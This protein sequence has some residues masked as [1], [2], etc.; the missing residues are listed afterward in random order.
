[1]TEDPPIGQWRGTTVYHGTHSGAV[2][3]IADGLRVPET[4][5]YFGNAFYTAAS[6]ASAHMT[7]APDAVAEH[8]GEP[9]VLAVKIS[10]TANILD[11]RVE[12]D[13]A[14]WFAISKKKHMGATDW[15]DF[16]TS[17]GI[18]GVFDRSTMGVAI[19]NP[20][21][22]EILGA[23][24]RTG[25][26]A[27]LQ[28]D[29]HPAL[30]HATKIAKERF[31]LESELHGFDHWERVERNGA[32]LASKSKADPLVVAIFARLHDCCRDD[33]HYDEEHGPK[34]ARLFLADAS[35]KKW[36]TPP[37][38]RKTA[39]ALSTHTEAAGGNADATVGVCLDSDRLDL[40]R[41][42]CDI[43]TSYLSTQAAID[44][45]ENY[46]A[47]EI[48]DGKFCRELSLQGKSGVQAR[49][50]SRPPRTV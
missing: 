5:G 38:I 48:M 11:L 17:N 20:S 4:G 41:L 21:A 50:V 16:M 45:A 32:Y 25:K 26:I 1:M 34:A 13:A 28:Q 30:R 22:I 10:P 36:L 6:N 35:F 9:A 49:N 39:A 27:P 46:S 47:D 24:D 29:E 7:W 23:T 19:F 37:Q 42:G 14:A 40:V 12:K 43:D 33:D 2:E 18:D 8:G 3:S 31:H 15:H 44:V